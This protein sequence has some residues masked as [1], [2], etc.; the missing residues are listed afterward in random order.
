MPV[1]LDVTVGGASA[2]SFASDAEADAYHAN[3]LNS[4]AW[5]AASEDDQARALIEATRDLSMLGFLGT[6]V[7][8]VQ[9][10]SWPRFNA[11]NPDGLSAFEVFG[12]TVIPQRVKD[13]TCELALEFLRAGTTDIATTDPN[14]GV[15][16]KTVDVLTTRWQPGQRPIG[17]TRY[18]RVLKLISPLL[19]VGPGRVRLTR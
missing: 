15:I 10:L 13:A 17:L 4:G 3:R 8:S 5:T 2:N 7:D 6:R 11:V 16:E 1:S 18:P 14:N 19:A 9:V 12:T